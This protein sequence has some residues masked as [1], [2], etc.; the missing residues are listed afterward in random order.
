SGHTND[1]EEIVYS[2]N[3]NVLVTASKESVRVW[4]A[5]TGELIRLLEK[6]RYPVAFSPDGRTLATAGQDRTVLLWDVP[7]R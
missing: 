7:V 6:A 4:N 1:I 3:G 5:V 2:P